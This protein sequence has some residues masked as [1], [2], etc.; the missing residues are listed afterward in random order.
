[1]GYVAYGEN[2]CEHKKRRQE[3][4]EFPKCKRLLG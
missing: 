4:S 1:M 2:R 3:I